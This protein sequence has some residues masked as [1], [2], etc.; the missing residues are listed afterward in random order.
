MR[1]GGVSPLVFLPS[2]PHHI[3]KK[4]GIFLLMFVGGLEKYVRV[5][6]VAVKAA[7]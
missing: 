5:E 6:G 2:P 7:E 1:V 4:R 3:K